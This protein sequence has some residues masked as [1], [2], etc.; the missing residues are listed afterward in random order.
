M[1]FFIYCMIVVLL[2]FIAGCVSENIVKSQ[3]V[4]QVPEVRQTPVRLLVADFNE[5]V[6]S[7]SLGGVFGVWD[8]DPS[9][10][11][12]YC[13]QFYSFDSRNGRNDS[14]LGLMYD[15]ESLEPAFNGFWMRLAGLNLVDYDSLEFDVK[16]DTDTGFTSLFKVEL[17]NSDGEADS[18]YVKNITDQWQTV[19]ISLSEFKQITDWTDMHEFVIVFEDMR[20][21]ELVGTIYIDN[22]SFVKNR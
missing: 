20:S 14:F 4:L 1:R 18:F 6:N 19:V 22:I 17:K 11:T 8:A 15:V 12:Q 2:D 5:E 16:G 13:K 3:H 10:E 21:T 7:N 9:D